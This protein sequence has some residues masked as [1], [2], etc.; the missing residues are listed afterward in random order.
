M[1]KKKYYLAYG[2]NLNVRQ[3]ARR[4]P[5][6]VPV[7]TAEI[8]DYRLLFKGSKSGNY[9]TIEKHKGSSVPV[10]VWMVDAEDER[11]LDRYEG[12]PI[13]YYKKRI[14]IDIADAKDGKLW[15]VEAFVYIMHE[16]HKI[17]VPSLR[18][19]ESCAEGYDDFGF[20]KRKL[21]GAVEYSLKNREAA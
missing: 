6:A 13:F 10:G 11:A 3:M 18:Y 21:V 15:N 1:A 12:Y 5:N 2:S 7:G 16:D 9:L 20:D 8:K 14:P 17:G 4:C 19:V